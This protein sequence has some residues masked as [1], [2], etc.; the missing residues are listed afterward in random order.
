MKWLKEKIFSF[1]NKSKSSQFDQTKI[2]P[3]FDVSYEDYEFDPDVI[4]YKHAMF[5]EIDSLKFYRYFSEC[6]YPV[7]DFGNELYEYKVKDSRWLFLVNKKADFFCCLFD[8]LGD[9]RISGLLCGYADREKIRKC[10]KE[11]HVWCYY[12]DG[13]EFA[14]K[15]GFT[16]KIADEVGVYVLL[17]AEEKLVTAFQP[18]GLLYKLKLKKAYSERLSCET[19]D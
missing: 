2:I 11:Q 5:D 17:S 14:Q 10:L 9:L 6:S 16:G 8:D 18:R 12:P 7:Q 4:A 3:P 13:L 1:L 19:K 15:Y